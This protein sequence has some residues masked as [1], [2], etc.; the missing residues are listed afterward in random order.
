MGSK[1]LLS[2]TPLSLFLVLSVVVTSVISGILGMAGGMILM[3]VYGWLLPIPVA[4]ALHGATQ[5][6]SNGFR[7]W[8]LRKHVRAAVL[9]PYAAG[10]AV[11]L[12]TFLA[13]RLV[14]PRPWL[15]LLLGLIP[16]VSPLLAHA[17]GGDAT[18]PGQAAAC[19]LLVTTCQLSAGVSGPLLDVFFLRTS[20]PPL[21]IVGTKAVTQSLGHLLKLCYFAS[22]ALALPPTPASLP[23]AIV[24]AVVGAAMIGT[25]VGKSILTRLPEWAFRSASTWV[26]RLLGAVYVTKGVSELLGL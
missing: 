23:P 5:L 2:M 10:S 4:M 16:F 15:F 13:L 8:L 24:P 17:T 11:A 1:E 14:L 12:A 6:A 7:T 21:A 19:G 18:R 25:W 3:G 26:L 22:L 9:L 20:L